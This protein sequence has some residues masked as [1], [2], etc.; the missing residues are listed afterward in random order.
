MLL[1]NYLCS[2]SV[3][4]KGGGLPAPFFDSAIWLINEHKH[5]T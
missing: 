3:L 4:E 5:K 1:N 2:I